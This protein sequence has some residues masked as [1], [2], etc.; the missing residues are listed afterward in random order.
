MQFGVHI[1]TLKK[2]G[3]AYSL[4]HKPRRTVGPGSHA[5]LSQSLQRCFWTLLPSATASVVTIC[6]EFYIIGLGDQGSL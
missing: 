5:V 1:A 6:P 3:G 2:E 4:A